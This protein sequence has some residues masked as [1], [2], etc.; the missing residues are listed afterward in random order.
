M[1][2]AAVGQWI[3]SLGRLSGDIAFGKGQR[4][5]PRAIPQDPEI[6]KLS[7][8]LPL[9][10]LDLNLDDKGEEV[11]RRGVMRAIRHA[12]IFETTPIREMGPP[13]GLAMH[14]PEWL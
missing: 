12:A 11:G 3:R 7:M 14:P 4:M 2:L 10:G 9:S 5:P 1:S 6:S 13:M 8:N